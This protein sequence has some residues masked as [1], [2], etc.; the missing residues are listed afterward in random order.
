[1]CYKQK[2]FNELVAGD[3]KKQA[4]KLIANPHGSF[5]PAVLRP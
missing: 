2:S 1:M 4:G 5:A 3:A